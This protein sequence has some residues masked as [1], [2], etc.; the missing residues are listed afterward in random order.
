MLQELDF[1]EVLFILFY[2]CIS[3]EDLRDLIQNSHKMGE[4]RI[5]LFCYNPRWHPCPGLPCR[6]KICP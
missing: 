6:G 3:A 1:H 2:T 4:I 5:N